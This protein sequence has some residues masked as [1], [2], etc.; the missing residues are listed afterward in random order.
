MKQP[1]MTHMGHLNP[2]I[3]S[4]LLFKTFI[5][6]LARQLYLK[7]TKFT[8][9][10]SGPNAFFAKFAAASDFLKHMS[11]YNWE[12][13]RRSRRCLEQLAAENVKEVFVYG[14]RDVTEVLCNLAFEIPVKVIT[15]G[16]Y[17]KA[18]TDL[19]P[20]EVPIEMGTVGREK[21]IIGS[22]V[23]IEERTRR[24]RKMGVDDK[25]IVLLTDGR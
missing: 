18:L 23:N 1:G 15:L 8:R 13:I 10:S 25:R 12:V 7:L 5:K 19:A 3:V 21:I 2:A 20:H 11:R 17:Y 24:L 4:V 22:L 14:E 16:E 6:T 9:R